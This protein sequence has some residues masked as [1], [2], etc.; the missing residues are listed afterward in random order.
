MLKRFVGR[1]QLPKLLEGRVEGATDGGIAC[2]SDWRNRMARRS[3][4]PQLVPFVSSPNG[5]S[6]SARH[7][8]RRPRRQRHAPVES[9]TRPAILVVTRRGL[10]EWFDGVDDQSW[11]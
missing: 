7:R 4:G 6:N 11:R 5:T 3:L 1:F 2:S 9:R 8:L 10:P